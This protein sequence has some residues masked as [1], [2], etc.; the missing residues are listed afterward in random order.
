MATEVILPKVD[1]VMESAT[2]VEWLK[3]EGETVEKGQPLFVI[4]TD[5]AAMEIESP[6]SGILAGLRAEPNQ[7]LPVSE[8]IAYILQPGEALPERVQP[9]TSLDTSGA[10]V[11]NKESG[12]NDEKHDGRIGPDPSP[13]REPGLSGK[14]RA[15]PVA[16]KLAK[17]L[18]VDL[19]N[20]TGRGPRGRIHR[21]DVEQAVQSAPPAIPDISTPPIA[22][23]PVARVELPQARQRA[24]IPLTGPRKIIADRMSY[25]AAVAPHIHL[26][27]SVDMGEGIRLRSSVQERIERNSGYKLSHTAILARATTACL[28]SHPFLNASLDGDRIIQWQDVHLGIATSLKDYLI[29]PVIREAQTKNLEELAATLGD[30]LDRARAMRLNPGEMGGS[31]FT[32][33]NLGMYGIESFTAIINP[34]EAAILAVGKIVETCVKVNDEKEF[35]PLMNLTICADHRMVD[36]AA[37]AEFLIDLKN[38]LENPYRLI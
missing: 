4:L 7:V 10:A 3:R 1:M 22:P 5:K 21:A 30:L 34:P 32:I 25:S 23:I 27:V 28:M 12:P 26:S 11:T 36:G 31:T 2:F 9:R 16:R 37:A 19:A 29:V 15:T 33:S 35:R 14:L 17:E 6:A 24:V 20:L 8:V 18:G 38:I 13:K